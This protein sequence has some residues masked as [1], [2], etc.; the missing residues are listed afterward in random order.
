MKQLSLRGQNVISGAVIGQAARDGCTEIL[1]DGDAVVTSLALDSAAMAGIRLVREGDARRFDAPA[2]A[3]AAAG[4]PAS[5]EVLFASAEARAAKDEIVAVGR[6]LWQRSYVDGN[7]GN[8]S[9]RIGDK[10]VLCTP[11]LVSKGDLTPDDLCLVDLDGNQIA[12]R[13]KKTS[14]ILLHL[15]IMKAQPKARACVHA[16]PPHATA[17]AITGMVPPVRVIPEAEI[18]VG[19]AAFAPYGTPGTADISRHVVELVADHNT[20]LLGNH[21][22]ICWADTPLR[23]EWCIEILET[24]CQTL[25]IASQLNV[26]IKTIPS[27]KSAAL[28]DTKRKLNLPDPRLSGRACD[29]ED[30]GSEL[31]GITVCPGACAAG[32]GPCR[33]NGSCDCP[34]ER[35]GT[36]VPKRASGE[37]EAL[38]GRIV[39]EVMKALGR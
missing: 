26:P 37:S 39:D 1:I 3:F 11:T 33:L 27:D 16:H 5:P 38:I 31:T 34:R 21:G 15:E 13:R 7:G 22:V 8:I 4:G 35:T 14:E 19:Y 17:Y 10:H 20:I 24:Y 28:L 23:A 18:F 36:P 29:G 9:C 12:G 6:K 30:L 25:L 2:G 32:N